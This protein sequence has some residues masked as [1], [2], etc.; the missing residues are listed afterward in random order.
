VQTT[1]TQVVERVTLDIE[2]FLTVWPLLASRD[3]LQL[4]ESS[5]GKR[6]SVYVA[7]PPEGPERVEILLDCQAARAAVN[8]GSGLRFGQWTPDGSAVRIVLEDGSGDWQLTGTSV[9]ATA[10]WSPKG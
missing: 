5:S 9:G 3:L 1:L 8:S 7:G 6:V 10:C 4:L 2:S